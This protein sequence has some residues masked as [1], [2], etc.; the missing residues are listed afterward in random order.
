MRLFFFTASNRAAQK[1]LRDTINNDFDLYKYHDI[2]DEEILNKLDY[3]KR[4]KMWGATPG[5]SNRRNWKEL[6]EGYR[7]LIYGSE[8]KFIKYGK[9]IGKTRNKE[10]ANAAWGKD[11]N[12]ETWE[13]IF[14][15]EIL[16]E[17]DIDVKTFNK[18]VGYNTNFNPQGFTYLAKK[19]LNDLLA[20]F[21]T[22]DKAVKAMDSGLDTTVG[23]KEVSEIIN[24][25]SYIEKVHKYILAE[26][27]IYSYEEIA[28]FYLALKTKS[29]VILSGISG[30]GKSKLVRIFAEAIGA[31]VD[32]NRFK[33]ISVKPDWNDATELIGYKNIKDEFIPGQLTEVIIKAIN[34][35]DKPYFICL[36]E[37]NLARIE[38]Y[39]SDYLSLI[40]S[41]KRVEDEIK[42]DSLINNVE[43]QPYKDLYIPENL[44]LVGTVNM[45][46][47]TFGFSNKV[48]DRTNS[49][50]F[51]DVNLSKLEFI[52]AEIDIKAANNQF[53]K[54]SFLT[55][56][57]ALAD[58]EGYVKKINEEVRKI[59][60]ILK[61]YNY[62]FAYRTRD[63]IVF[64]ML[65]NHKQGLLAEDKA[66]DYQ[67][68]QKILPKIIGSDV[69]I[70]NALID[71]YNYCNQVEISEGRNYIKDAEDNLENTDYPKSSKKIIE[72]LKGYENGFTSYWV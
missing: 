22:I 23:A 69:K 15:V 42:T 29:F 50:E 19:K 68:S 59:N 49:I 31:T 10:L 38:Y 63:E 51:T 47:T 70:K 61:K 20:E 7:F 8:Q 39:F 66:F 2:V 21:E 52:E 26:G 1:H 67:I 72:M 71:L 46:D 4:I 18:T 55:I 24:Y 60:Q 45:D 40:E 48:L 28:N 13:Y 12:N 33:M 34:N 6:E 56:Q 14:F 25:K 5:S 9:V 43:E 35:P 32:N 44:Y 62:H 37:M 36:D 17:V 57:E 16:K 41:K 64:Y 3:P 58:N 54:Q 11:S 27:Y 53:L 30:T 65:E